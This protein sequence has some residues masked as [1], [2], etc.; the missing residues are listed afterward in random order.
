MHVLEIAAW[1]GVVWWG[2]AC[3]NVLLNLV[4][5]PRLA[6]ESPAGAPPSLSV[7]I[8]ARDEEAAVED[9][10]TSHCIQD[11]PGLQVVVVDD[12]STDGTGAILE[13]LSRRF[14][15][16]EVVR[17]SEPPEGWL[18]KAHALALGLGR[19][20][21]ELV[22]LA[23]ADVRFE[24][25]VHRQAAGEMTR[26]NLDMLQLLARLEGRGLEP[27]VLSLFHGL[28]LFAAPAY[29]VNV[30]AFRHAAFG[31]STGMM[32]RREAFEAAGGMAGVRMKIPNDLATGR[33]MKAYRG[34]YFV[35]T[36]FGQI[37]VR[38]Y[39][40]FRECIEGFTK[41][42]FHFFDRNLA[43]SSMLQTTDLAVEAVPALLLP[44][45]AMLPAFAPI[46]LPILIEVATAA[47]CNAAAC[48]WS[49]QPLWIVRPVLWSWILCRSAWRYYRQG[50]VWRGRR[51]EKVG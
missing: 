34:R 32:V 44:L 47:A 26:R 36:A 28:A 37:A 12:R 35:V 40:G 5:I 21:G 9:A 7:V 39:A 51:Y 41:N 22:L 25:G 49:R 20:T 18:G 13:R 27:L 30:P 6:R 3:L 23:D 19:A 17:G 8:P 31:A 16:L 10:V 2:L 29:L 1:C 42:Y 48:L 46:R 33:M 15:Q 24:P 14:P 4:L 45:A 43:L 50:V 11:Y 38:M